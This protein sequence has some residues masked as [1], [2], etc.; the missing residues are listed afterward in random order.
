MLLQC[1]YMY[2][3]TLAYH[4]Y[5][6]FIRAPTKFTLYPS[7]SADRQAHTLIFTPTLLDL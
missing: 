2:V 6:S 5:Y 7:A 3:G 4:I 1:S